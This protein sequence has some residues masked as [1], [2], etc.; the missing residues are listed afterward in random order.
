MEPVFYPSIVELEKTALIDGTRGTE[1]ELSQQTVPISGETE[2]TG[3]LTVTQTCWGNELGMP[4]LQFKN[5]VYEDIIYL[6]PGFAGFRCWLSSRACAIG[7]GKPMFGVSVI[8]LSLLS[9]YYDDP[10]PWNINFGVDFD[11]LEIPYGR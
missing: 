4:S 5:D 11:A 1:L 9:D 2:L 3:T 7:E 10:G 6:Y 8:R